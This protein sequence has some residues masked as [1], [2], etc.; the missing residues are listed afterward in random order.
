LHRDLKPENIFVDSDGHVR[1]CDLG[2]IKIAPTGTT[3]CGT[4]YYTSPE[5]VREEEYSAL[6]DWWSFS[7]MVFEMVTR[8]PPYYRGSDEQSQMRIYKG[9]IDPVLVPLDA[10]I[11]AQN[12]GLRHFLSGI[13]D[14]E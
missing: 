9:I 10:E 1:L 6:T 3:F 12:P 14:K 2:T 8:A 4:P 11:F 5:R 7:I 13:L